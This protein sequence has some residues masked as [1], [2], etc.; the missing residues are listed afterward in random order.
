MGRYLA[1]EKQGPG[2]VAALTALSSEI[3]SPTGEGGRI[4]ESVA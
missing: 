3:E 1:E 4:V 2:L